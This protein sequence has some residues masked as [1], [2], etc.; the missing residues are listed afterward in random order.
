M[1]RKN[2]QTFLSI[3]LSVL[4][5]NIF[6]STVTQYTYIFYVLFLFVVRNDDGFKVGGMAHGVPS[7]LHPV[8]D[9]QHQLWSQS[10][11]FAPQHTS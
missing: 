11:V 2:N 3:S 4:P 8:D 1:D 10:C 7:G 9:G 5:A 6:V